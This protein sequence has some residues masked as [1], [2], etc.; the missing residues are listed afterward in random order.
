MQSDFLYDTPGR[1]VID[2]AVERMVAI[3]LYINEMKRRHE[4]LMRTQ[5]LQNMISGT[6]RCDLGS[7]GD[8]VL[9]VMISV[10]TLNW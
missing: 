4:R 8:L 5:E 1:E 7:Y 10:Y 9:E 3:A 2:M 6:Q